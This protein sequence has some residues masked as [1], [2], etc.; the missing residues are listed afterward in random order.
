[1]YPWLEEFRRVND[2]VDR[3][4]VVQSDLSR[5]LDLSKRWRPVINVGRWA[6]TTWA[7]VLA[8]LLLGPALGH[9]YVLSYD[10]VWVPDLTLRPDFLGVGSGLPRAVPSDAVVSVLDAIIPGMLLQKV[11]LL[12]SLVSGGVGAALLTDTTSV[13]ARLVATTVYEWSA[14]VGERLLMGH[15]PVLL[16]FAALP[17]VIL[18]CQSWR[19][20][21]RTPVALWF[22]S[23]SAASAPPRGWSPRSW[24][25]PSSALEPGRVPWGCCSPRTP[26]G[27][28]RASCTPAAP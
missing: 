10:M 17:W 3:D 11:V 27:S 13:T 1:M 19:R 15:W 16:G 14:F 8:L 4:G 2:T 20:S 18:A 6:P 26:R 23:R 9:G 7:L 21:G 5:R 22:C 28:C 25:S 24:S 12:G